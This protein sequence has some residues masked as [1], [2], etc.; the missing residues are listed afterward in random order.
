MRRVLIVLPLLF[1]AAA[2]SDDL[3]AGRG[4][5]PTA[6]DLD[7]RTFLSTD[8]AGRTLVAGTRVSIGFEGET[9]GAAAGCNTMAG[10]FTVDDGAL[11]TDG[12]L[13]T[14]MACDT[15]TDAQDVWLSGLL[16]ESPKVL[17]AGDVLTITGA[18]S[19]LVLRDRASIAS[20]SVVDGGTWKLLSAETADG[21]VEAPAAANLSFDGAEVRLVTGC[22]RGS[23]PVDVVDD[24]T[25]DFGPMMLTRKACESPLAEF[26]QAVLVTLDGPV[27]VT[28]QGD[29]LVLASDIGIVRAELLP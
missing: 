16:T 20:L 27:T 9:V 18:D 1:A 25:L 28:L 12:F 10:G 17:L 6:A 22:N 5:V 19:Q 8:V 4:V 2:C 21:A 13:T 15:R 11:V 14:Q 7:G 29:D 26:E 23:G 3:D 24:D